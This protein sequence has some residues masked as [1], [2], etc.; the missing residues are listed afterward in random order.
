MI[1]TETCERWLPSSQ[2]RCRVTGR[3]LV[4]CPKER[5]KLQQYLHYY[6][7]VIVR[8]HSIIQVLLDLMP[9]K[10]YPLLHAH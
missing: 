6:K 2:R 7:N 1:N 10:N 9:F 3:L 8:P 5:V 4:K